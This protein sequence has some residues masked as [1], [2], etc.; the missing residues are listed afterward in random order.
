MSTNTNVFYGFK[1]GTDGDVI[2]LE[3]I[4]ISDLKL[5][6]LVD[7]SYVPTGYIDNCLVRV[8]GEALNTEDNLKEYFTKDGILQNLKLSEMETALLI[9]SNSQ[10]TGEA[11]NLYAVKMQADDIEINLLS[12]FLGNYLDIDNWAVDNFIV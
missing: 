6:P 12:S 2:R 10:D 1:Q 5:L 7:A 4:G 9:L 11:Q 8:F 3:N